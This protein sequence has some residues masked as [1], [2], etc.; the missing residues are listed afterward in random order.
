MAETSS[1]Q[2]ILSLNG[3]MHLTISR[4]G[5]C[6]KM[7]VLPVTPT[8]SAL[9]GRKPPPSA[10]PGRSKGTTTTKAMIAMKVFLH[11]ICLDLYPIS[12]GD[13]EEHYTHCNH[14]ATSEGFAAEELHIC[15]CGCD[16][17]SEEYKPR[18]PFRWSE[19]SLTATV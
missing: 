6:P 10:L 16:P 13:A 2:S 17:S 8:R 18:Y 5:V 4:L 3:A 9:P 14:P 15:L 11:C 1:L 19:P 12:L 7:M